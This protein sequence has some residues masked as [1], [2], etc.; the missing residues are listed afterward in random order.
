MSYE[1]NCHGLYSNQ[2]PVVFCPKYRHKILP[3]RV[4]KRL[5][6]ILYQIAD[7]LS[8]EIL[9]LEVRPD[10]LHILC[11]VDPPFG[12]YKFVKRVKGVSS[13][14]LRQEFPA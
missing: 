5:K 10:H 1:S 9:E 6:E 13:P 3:G 2:Y 11:E 14:W 7:E 8:C 4:D 12:V